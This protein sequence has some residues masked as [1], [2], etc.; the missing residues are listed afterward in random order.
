MG[1]MGKFDCKGIREFQK[2]LENLQKTEKAFVEACA[3][4]L[5]GR[6]LRLVIEKTPRGD[7]SREVEVTAKRNSKKHKKGEVYKKRVTP[8]GKNGGTLIRGWVSA[9]QEEAKSGKGKPSR[10]EILEYANGLQVSR[11][12]D[13]YRID[14]VNPVEYAS[15]VEH[16]HRTANHKGWV[17][18]RFMMTIS[19]QELE[20]IAPKVLENRIRKYLEAAMK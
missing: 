11:A 5:A 18:G 1:K 3:K 12:G 17:R 13:T 14:I 15:Y 2:Q 6:L 9:T 10:E 19:E 4:N 8:S 16:G 20:R 7:Y